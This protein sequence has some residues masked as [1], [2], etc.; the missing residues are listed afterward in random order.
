[1]PTILNGQPY[2]NLANAFIL[3]Y[4]YNG[5]DIENFEQAYSFAQEN[6]NMLASETKKLARANALGIP[7]ISIIRPGCYVGVFYFGVNEWVYGDFLPVFL[8]FPGGW[9]DDSMGAA[10]DY[11]YNW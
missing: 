6:I 3:Y 9:N 8:H 1:V 2:T 5:R 7:F 10:R 11:T 4:I